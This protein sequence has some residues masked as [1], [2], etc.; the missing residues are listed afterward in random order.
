M[1]RFGPS[2]STTAAEV[3][4]IEA[5][6]RRIRAING[7]PNTPLRSLA[8]DVTRFR[9]VLRDATKLHDGRMLAPA[10]PLDDQLE[11]GTAK[12][13][14]EGVRRGARRPPRPAGRRLEAAPPAPRGVGPNGLQSHLGPRWAQHTQ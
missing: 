10:V 7:L 1:T 11:H 9:Q 13:S 6:L 2:R 12:A 8:T 3:A 5:L 4:S 14:Y